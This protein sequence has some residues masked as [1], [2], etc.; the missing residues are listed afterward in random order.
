VARPK[1]TRANSAG[2]GTRLALLA[3]AERLFAERGISGVSLREIGR[4]AMQGNNNVV[5][6][7][8]GSKENLV[9]QIFH[10]RVGQMEQARLRMIEQAERK[11]QLLNC[12][13]IVDIW[14]LPVLGLVAED[15]NHP[16]AHFL[17]HYLARYRPAG[18]QHVGDVS[19]NEFPSLTKLGE[20]LNRAVSH[21][22]PRLRSQRIE[23]AFQIFLSSIV[24][25]DLRRG[26]EEEPLLD[27]EDVLELVATVLCQ[28]AGG[29]SGAQVTAVE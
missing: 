28:R 23:L 11:G 12:R 7:H 24:A 2:E 15:G 17:A 26:C 29:P 21:L 19:P 25:H 27:L 3:I 6:Y 14:C 18:I 10:W 1:I 4:E 5:Q 9:S 8:F 13:T 22:P 16:Y 20:C